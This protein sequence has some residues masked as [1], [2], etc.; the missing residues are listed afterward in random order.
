MYLLFQA[1][2]KFKF[3]ILKNVPIVQ[4]LPLMTLLG[5]FN[6]FRRFVYCLGAFIF[7]FCGVID[8]LLLWFLISLGVNKIY[9]LIL[10]NCHAC[11]LSYSQFI[12]GFCSSGQFFLHCNLLC[13]APTFR[14]QMGM[15]VQ[16]LTLR[17]IYRTKI[18][19]NIF[20]LRIIF[21]I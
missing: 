21:L 2:V 7:F 8:S 11:V 3:D 4:N 18:K 6:V 17:K 20:Y 16:H 1:S 5:L 10:S 15:R 9:I 12:F 19:I 13:N 14:R